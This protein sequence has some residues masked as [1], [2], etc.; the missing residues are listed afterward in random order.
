MAKHIAK[1]GVWELIDVY[2]I[3]SKKTRKTYVCSACKKYFLQ[4]NIDG[5]DRDGF[6]YCPNCG[7]RMEEK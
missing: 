7:A 1:R 2:Y 5:D 3:S 4:I 6:N